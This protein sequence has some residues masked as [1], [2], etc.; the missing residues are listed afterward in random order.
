MYD[1]APRLRLDDRK[2]AEAIGHNAVDAL[3]LGYENSIE[4]YSVFNKDNLIVGMFG[5]SLMELNGLSAVVWFLGSDEIEK[6][7]I[8]FIRE[9]KKFINKLKNNYKIF[10]LV[11]SENKTHIEYIKRLGLVV[12]ETQEIQINGEVFHPFYS[13]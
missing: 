9:G 2:E 11:Y 3:K 1:L 12:D 10:N 7:P 8:P 5:Y 13:S 4:C 6:Y